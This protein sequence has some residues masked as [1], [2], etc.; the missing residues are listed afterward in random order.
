MFHRTQRPLLFSFIGLNVLYLYVSQDSTSFVVSFIG[1]NVLCLYISRDSMHFAFLVSQDSMS[2]IVMFHRTQRHLHFSFIG[3]NVL[4]DAILP[5]KGIGQK[6][7]SRLGQRCKRRPQ[8]SYEPQGRFQAHGLSTSPLIFVNIRLRF[9]YFWALYLG[10]HNVGR[11]PQKYR[12]FQPL[13][14]RAPRLVIVLGVVL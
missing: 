1:L 6:T 8:G 9:H 14:F 2:S 10:L 13:Y 3:L 11:V 4:C 12:I 5:R 7:P